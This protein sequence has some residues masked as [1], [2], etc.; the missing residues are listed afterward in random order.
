MQF[1][2]KSIDRID[3]IDKQGFIENYY[4]PQKPVVIK[5]IT[6]DWP[7]YAKWNLDY[8]KEIAGERIV[9]LYNS[10]PVKAE[11]GFN[12]PKAKMSLVDY[13]D[14][15]KSEPTDLR[16]FLYNLMKEVPQLQQDY[17]YPELGLKIM[18]GLPMLFFGGAG[19][20]VFMH[21]DIDLANIFHFHFHGEKECILVPPSQSKF[22]YKIPHSV[23]C[24]EDID[25]DH[26]DF[27]KFPALK[28]LKPYKTTLSHGE[29]LYMPEAYWHYMKYITPGFS[30]SL[31]SI[32]K[33]PNHL[34]EALY[35]VILM[36]HYDSVMRKLKGNDWIE[37]KNQEAIRRTHKSLNIH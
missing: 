10:E 35:N 22:M 20:N 13:V 5:N 24:R 25:F 21:Y 7:A 17:K 8:I 27:E 6:K 1:D 4:K 30:M 11:D 16:I 18:K 29:M 28:N 23:I 36:R 34:A 31:R 12:E 15:L 26:P 19:S 32:A 33:R 37:Y 2:F 3:S 9:P 14:L